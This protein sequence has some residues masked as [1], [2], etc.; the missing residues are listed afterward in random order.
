[1][2]ITQLKEPKQVKQHISYGRYEAPRLLKMEDK[3]MEHFGYN[4]SQLHKVLIRDAYS[5]MSLIAV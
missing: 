4:R 5:K 2:S 1:M 3:L